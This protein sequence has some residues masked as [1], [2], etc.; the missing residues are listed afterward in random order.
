MELV[1]GGDGKVKLK[2]DQLTS[3]SG[4]GVDKLVET[5]KFSQTTLTACSLTACSLVG[6][7]AGLGW[8]VLVYCERK[9]LLTD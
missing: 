4:E 9:T 7:W 8:L 5:N 2:A 6:F 1:G 3:S